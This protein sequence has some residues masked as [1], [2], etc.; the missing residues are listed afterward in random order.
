MSANQI[1]L[2]E[3]E[4]KKPAS[5]VIYIIYIPIS[6]SVATVVM[7]ELEYNLSCFDS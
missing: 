5:L 4:K 2:E 6:A 1:T 3:E 7:R